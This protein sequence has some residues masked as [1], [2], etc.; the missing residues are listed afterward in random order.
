MAEMALSAKK[1]A[2]LLVRPGRYIDGG[3]L[4][5]GLYLQVTEGGA[6][7]LL[8]YEFE[9][10]TLKSGKPTKPNGRKGRR[11]RWMGLGSLGDFS[12]KEARARAK[13][14]RQL[15]ADGIDPLDQKETVKKAKALAKAKA[16]TFEEA[17]RQYFDQHSK[18]WRNAKH[19]EQW[20]STLETYAYPII[21]ALAVADVD[22]G[23]VLRVLEQKR[24]N[25][26]DQRLWDA[27]PETASRLRGRIEKV[28]A[29]CTTRNFRSGDNPAAWKNHLDNVLPARG[30]SEH[31]PALPYADDP[32][33]GLVGIANFI[34]ALRG[35]EGIAARALEFLILTAARTGAVIGATRDEID[36]ENKVWSV[37]PE[38][39]GTKITGDDPKPRRIPLSDRALEILKS[40]PHEEGNPFVFIGGEAGC[41]L[42][43]AA[44]AELMKDMAFASTTKGRLAVPHGMRSTFK[45]WCADCTNYANFVSEAALWHAVADKVEASYRR[46]ELFQKRIRLMN[47]W[48]KY[49]GSPKRDASVADLN[50]RRKAGG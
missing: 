26:P 43:N 4:G 33:K 17:A 45:D 34:V 14:K 15:L 47:D 29:W 23:Q 22:T 41:G 36:F 40:L 3:D 48:A 30:N 16:I 35:R 27:V 21:G 38:R 44:M 19:R 20:T 49:C 9:C 5:Q 37:P 50:A 32:E 12:L 13:Q 46:G 8:R 31:Y 25:Y 10:A 6:S 7:W 24:A 39:A 1:I 11:E 42:S 28:L 2:K 18:K